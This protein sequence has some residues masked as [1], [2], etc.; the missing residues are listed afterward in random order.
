MSAFIQTS[1]RQTGI[2]VRVYENFHV[3]QVAQFLRIED[4]DAF[5]NYNISSVD[6]LSICHPG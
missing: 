1:S 5:Q 3:E 2:S 6:C 4:K